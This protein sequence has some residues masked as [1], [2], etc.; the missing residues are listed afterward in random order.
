MSRI[1]NSPVPL[2]SGVEVKING[3]E[4]SVKGA[5]GTLQRTFDPRITFN[6][7]DGEVEVIRTNDQRDTR[8][9]HGLSRALLNNMVVGVSEDRGTRRNRLRGSR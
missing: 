9:L 4:V 1:G 8:A 7:G 3:S 5:K 2:P 6:M